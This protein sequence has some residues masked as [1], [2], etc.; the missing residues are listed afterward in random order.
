MRLHLIVFP[1]T[2]SLMILAS[3]CTFNRHPEGR[4]ISN[5]NFDW[6]FFKGDLPGGQDPTLNDSDWREIDLPHDWSIEGPFSKEYASGT[7]Y[8][9]GGIGW[10]RK[11]FVIPSKYEDKKVF[12]SFDGVYNNSEVWIN[13][14]YLGKRPYGYISFQYDLTPYLNFGKENLI[15]VKVDHSKFGDS[16]WY[17]G[18]GIYRDVQLIVTSPVH[19]EQWGVYAASK[20]VTAEKAILDIEVSV[21]NEL[22]E[23]SNV[24]VTNYLLAGEDT[25]KKITEE[26]TLAPSSKQ[27]LSLQMDISNPKLWDLDNPYLYSLNTM[28]IGKGILDN[29]ATRIGFRDIRFD[30]DSGFFLNG[31]NLKMKGICMHHDAGTLGAAVPWQ[32]IERRLDILKELGC[33]AIRTSHNPFS[34]YFQHTTA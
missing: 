2:I 23:T 21:V 11:S 8:L 26:L 29:Q 9:P 13:G 34:S 30:S 5:F 22:K 32:V 24:K 31:E 3:S 12:I 18:S 28:V 16:R 10:Y 14:A 1:V 6:K 7:G 17:T 20:V 33:N 4:V 25:V 19:I 15:A 27:L